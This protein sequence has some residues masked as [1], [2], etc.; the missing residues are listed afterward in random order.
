M[1]LALF[2]FDGT[3]TN[4]DSFLEFIKFTHGSF[5]FWVGMWLLSPVLFLYFIKIIPNHKA[6]AIVLGYFFKGWTEVWLTQYGRKFA[7]RVLPKML[8]PK[9]IEK[10]NWHKE[11]G[12]HVYLISA[13]AEPWLEGWCSQQDIELISTKLNYEQGIFK[14]KLGS[15]NCY[16]QEK[17]NRIKQEINLE[18]YSTVYAY[19]DSR[20]DK[21][22]LAI[23]DKA[24]FKPFR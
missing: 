7:D 16:G 6:K 17:V 13:S 15:A 1:Q 21:E 24:Y 4:K 11:Q 14:G 22:M 18:A 19:G 8:R 23:A 2:D 5:K 3:I 12:H 10:L 9:A 20:G